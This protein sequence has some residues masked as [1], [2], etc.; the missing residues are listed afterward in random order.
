MSV[1]DS[2]SKGFQAVY[3][4]WWLVLIPILLDSVLWLGP[5]LSVHSMLQETMVAVNAQFSEMSSQD[6]P[7]WAD[8]LRSTFEDAVSRYNAFAALRVGVLGVP[9][10]LTWGGVR[11]GSPPMN[12]A[13]WVSFLGVTNMPDLMLSVSDAS[14]ATPAVWQIPNQGT[15]LLLTLSLTLAGIG[16][17]SVYLTA[18]WQ[19]L[20]IGTELPP[21][22]QRALHL[23]KR[24]V[25]FLVVRAVALLILGI[26]FVLMLALLSA[27]STSAAMLFGTV[28][29]G[30]GTWLSFYLAFLAAAL[31]TSDVS[32]WRAVWNSFNVVLRNFWST[33]WLFALVNLIGGGLTILWQRLS[34][35]SWLTWIA[36]AGNAYIGS[37]LVAAGLVFYQDRYQRWQQAIIE[38]L[39]KTRQRMA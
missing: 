6:D 23:C 33:L 32:V 24:C 22:W 20:G 9:S 38:L 31:A 25:L 3:R 16:A 37:S 12:E 8:A 17:G 15:W 13:L 21:F 4:R 26:P 30:L 14:F 10:L 34:T 36:I 19:S 28:V 11:L 29:L 5:R 27:I 18:I 7:E 39:S 35:G 2:L 1:I